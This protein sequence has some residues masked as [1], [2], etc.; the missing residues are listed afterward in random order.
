MKNKTLIRTVNKNDASEI[1]KIYAPVIEN[2]YTTFETK[3]PDIL[4]MEKRIENISVKYPWL[5]GEYDGEFAGYAYASEHRTR[6]AYRW[7]VDVSVYISEDHRSCGFGKNLYI[8]LFKILKDLGY[9]N[10]YAG[11]A[12]PNEG[13]IALHESFGFKKVAHYNRVGFKQNKWRDVGW[14]EYF[15]NNHDDYK[16]PQ[17][18]ELYSTYLEKIYK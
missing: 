16:N 11:I 18:P 6:S 17:E 3:V 8:K 2:S 14:W 15:I 1:L 13:S 9:F 4:E 5:V 10:I 12:L 7:S